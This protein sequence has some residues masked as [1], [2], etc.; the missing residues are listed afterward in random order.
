MESE[1]RELSNLCL[2]KFTASHECLYGMER[3]DVKG[4]REYR[5]KKREWDT[6]EKKRILVLLNIITEHDGDHNYNYYKYII[7]NRINRQVQAGQ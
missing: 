7:Q 4:K 5:G 6:L 1:L 3:L 2:I